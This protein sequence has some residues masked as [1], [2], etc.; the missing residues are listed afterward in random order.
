MS[1]IVISIDG[2]GI[3][4]IIPVRILSRIGIE[5]KDIDLIA[6]TSAGSIIASGLSF[7]EY[8]ELEHMFETNIKHIFYQNI[9]DKISSSGGIFKAKYDICNLSDTLKRVFNDKTLSSCK[10]NTLIPAYN[11]TQDKIKIFKSTQDSVPVHDVC[12]ASSAAPTF[13]NPK[14]IVGNCYVDGGVVYNNPAMVALTEALNLYGNDEK[15]TL[16]SLGCGYIKEELEIKDSGLIEWS[17]KLIDL[18]IR[19]QVEST[20]YL[21]KTNFPKINYIRLNPVMSGSIA[22]DDTKLVPMLK[23]L[24]DTYYIQEINKIGEMLNNI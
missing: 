8:D 2:G 16:I 15:I 3:K 14:N 9:S 18:F 5:K 23:R 10:I 22:L 19:G 4:G 20:N 13:F 12:A 7:F 21:I 24:A 17:P 11:I 6:G 1:K